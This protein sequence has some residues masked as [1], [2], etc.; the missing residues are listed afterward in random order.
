MI[1]RKYTHT[2]LFAVLDC[3]AV[4]TRIP[5]PFMSDEFIAKERENIAEH[6]IP[7]TKTWVIELNNKISGFISLIENKVVALFL[8]PDF[9][10]KGLGKALMDKAQEI[11]GDLAVEVF[12]SNSNARGFYSHYGFEYSS[13][14][15]HELTGQEVLHLKFK[16]KREA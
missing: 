5:H 1:I 4:S 9:Q 16:Q 12:K 13:E 6:Y 7:N 8:Y 11:H 10:G 14:S 15:F 3:W 2:D